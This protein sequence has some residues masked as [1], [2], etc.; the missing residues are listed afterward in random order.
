MVFV[1]GTPEQR[2]WLSVE[3]RGPGECWP[4]TKSVNDGY[5]HLNVLGRLVPAHRFSYELAF[6]P[7][8]DGRVIDHACH[9]PD[10]ECPGGAACHHRRC[11]NPVHLAPVTQAENNRRALTRRMHCPQGHPRTPDNRIKGSSGGKTRCRLC[12]RA[13]EA[14]R[15]AHLR[16]ATKKVAA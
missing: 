11:V 16:N 4:W 2:F 10:L 15:K 13:R 1:K 14:A 3:K 9:N 8:S 6:G 12:H 7:I 5:G